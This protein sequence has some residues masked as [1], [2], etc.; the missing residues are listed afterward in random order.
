MSA[1]TEKKNVVERFFGWM[2]SL[3]VGLLGLKKKDER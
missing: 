2:Y 3:V 1:E